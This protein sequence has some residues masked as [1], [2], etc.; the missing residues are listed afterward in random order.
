MPK[1]NYPIN[2]ISKNLTALAASHPSTETAE[3]KKGIN[4]EKKDWSF[5]HSS[6][7]ISQF[8]WSVQLP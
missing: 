6:I 1:K 2:Y 3:L 8:D 5:N 7:E 4:P